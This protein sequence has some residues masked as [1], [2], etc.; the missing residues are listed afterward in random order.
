M[1]LGDAFNRGDGAQSL[2]GCAACSACMHA[3]PV[4][5]RK[6]IV[7]LAYLAVCR[8]D[9]GDD[10]PEFESRPTRNTTPGRS[11]G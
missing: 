6:E 11:A 9:S 10:C 5:G 4:Q 7:C 2:V 8:R 3:V 1:N